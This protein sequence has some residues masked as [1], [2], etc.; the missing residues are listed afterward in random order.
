MSGLNS[1]RSAPQR[2]AEEFDPTRCAASGCPLRGTSDRGGSGR[3]LCVCHDGTETHLWPRITAQV[4]ETKW[5]ADFIADILQ[6]AAR[7][8]KPDMAWQD[9]ADAFWRESDPACMPSDA[10]R[11]N[12]SRYAYRM[13]GELRWRV[14]VCKARPEPSQ[15]PKYQAK[16]GN[17]VDFAEGIAA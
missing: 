7:T 15:W 14:G 11:F 3:F 16:R 12:P 2:N 9:F 1:R 10:E 5:L 4:R 6:M 17:V 8:T 13:L